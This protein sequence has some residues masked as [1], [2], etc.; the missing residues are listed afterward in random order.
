MTET[1]RSNSAESEKAPIWK[2]TRFCCRS[3]MCI[4]CKQRGNVYGD[5]KRR[6]RITHADKLTKAQADK[7]SSNW[8]EFDAQ[9]ELM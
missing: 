9:T 1:Q 7:M 4:D 8:R 2:C 5:L 3:G 6:A